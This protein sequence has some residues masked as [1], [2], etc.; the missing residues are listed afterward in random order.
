MKFGMSWKRSPTLRTRFNGTVVRPGIALLT[1]KFEL[2]IVKIAWRFFTVVGH[3]S[4]NVQ[5]FR[6]R[7]GVTWRWNLPRLN[8]SV[9][10]GQAIGSWNCCL[11]TSYRTSTVRDKARMHH[12]PWLPVCPWCLVPLRIQVRT[13]WKCTTDDPRVRDETFVLRISNVQLENNESGN[14]YLLTSQI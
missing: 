11:S 6:S 12:Q 2:S 9:N 8:R 5:L 7:L 14:S 13:R 3:D 4:Q 10:P 1:E